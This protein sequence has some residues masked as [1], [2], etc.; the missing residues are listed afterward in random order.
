V[1]PLYTLAGQE[2]HKGNILID[3]VYRR[4][5]LQKEKYSFLSASEKLGLIFMPVSMNTRGLS[6]SFA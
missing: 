4:R 6:S 3:Q 2:T 5:K 1:A